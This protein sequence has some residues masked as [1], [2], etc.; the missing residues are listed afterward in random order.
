MEV[1]GSALATTP[2]T[3]EHGW[4]RPLSE[5]QIFKVLS[6]Y[7]TTLLQWTSLGLDREGRS[8][9][10]RIHTQDAEGGASA[11]GLPQERVLS[12]CSTSSPAGQDPG[13]STEGTLLGTYP[14][15]VVRTQ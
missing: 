7:V 2:S 5:D 14:P 1:F 8:R 12:A 15:T 9:E 10:A 3:T 11:R 13:L 4:P 6:G